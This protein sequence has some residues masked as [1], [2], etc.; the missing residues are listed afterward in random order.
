MSAMA[1]VEL[2]A[3]GKSSPRLTPRSKTNPRFGFSLAVGPPRGCR[4]MA[5]TRPICPKSLHLGLRTGRICPPSL[6]RRSIFSCA[7]STE[8]PEHL[9]INVEEEKS[10]AKMDAEEAQVAWERTLDYI[11]EQAKKMQNLSQ[12]AYDVYSK[13][14][15]IILK[16]TSEKI[17]IQSKKAR[18]D[19]SVVAKEVGKGSKEY[20]TIA[21]EKSPESLKDVV[22]TFASST[23]ELNDV[24]EIRDFHLGIPYGSLLSVG[25]FLCFMLTGS[26]AAIRFG[27]ILGGTLL[28]LSVSS[29]RCW[30]KG[31]INSLALRG[32]AAIATILFLRELRL[33]FQRAFIAN[34]FTTLISGAMA[35]F[36]SY[37]MMISDGKQTKGSEN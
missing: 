7:A 34:I 37:R 23:D 18:S 29:L 11:R 21:A 13:K 4:A 9:D 36:F 26:I 27:V 22:E 20:L 3:A 32:Q 6:G 5:L 17:E 15:I 25:G 19:L 30:R 10:N 14:A 1:A 2:F 16:E 35:A 33:L 8:E 31:E 24:S 12:E 28:A